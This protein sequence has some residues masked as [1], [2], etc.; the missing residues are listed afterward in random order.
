MR[1]RR[2]E[3][4]TEISEEAY[5]GALQLISDHRDLLDEIAHKL[6]DN[7]VIEHDEIIAIMAGHRDSALS[8]PPRFDP[9]REAQ[10]SV[11][12]STP[13]EDEP[14][15]APPSVPPPRHR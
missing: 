4:V 12:A 13:A 9:D 14:A 15:D 7:E 6:L 2:D 5:R 11:T 1:Q 10:A 8:P 3:E